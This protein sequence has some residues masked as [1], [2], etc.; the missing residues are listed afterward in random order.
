MQAPKCKADKAI[1]TW[2]GVA[3]NQ[4]EGT[5]YIQFQVLPK[6]DIV[7]NSTIDV[8]QPFGDFAYG[9]YLT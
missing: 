7:F 8:Q 4:N 9:A 5:Q 2:V 3:V 1:G 6:G